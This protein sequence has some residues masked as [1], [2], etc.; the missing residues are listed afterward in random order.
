MN[1]NDVLNRR[2]LLKHLAAFAAGIF[3]I[4]KTPARENSQ[5]RSVERPIEPK[6]SVENM[7]FSGAWRFPH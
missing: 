4:S 5:P 6:D 3:L 7:G 2:S 1:E